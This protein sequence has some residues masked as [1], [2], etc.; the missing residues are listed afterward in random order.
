MFNLVFK[1]LCF[2]VLALLSSSCAVINLGPQIDSYEEVVVEEGTGDGKIL[3]I[4]IDGP[5]S[6]RPKKTLVGLQSETGM[7]DRIRE[8]LK[9]AENDES[10]KGILLRINSPGGTVTS[11][12]II[13][14]EIKSFK[15]RNKIKVYVSVID[16][17]AS[18]GYYVAMAGDSI[19][20]H[21]TSLVGSIGV[22][23]LKL[24]LEGLMSNVGVEWEVVKSSEKK[25]LCLRFAL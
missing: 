22:L 23:A 11:S 24:N 10:I 6:N 7:V 5:I 17:A 18:G 4:D 16:V 21:P 25:T 9:K 1:V 20:V 3:L 14:H 13:Y 2:F 8:M 15:E 19:M 12:D